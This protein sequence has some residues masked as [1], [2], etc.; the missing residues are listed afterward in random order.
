MKPTT[1]DFAVVEAVCERLASGEPLE[2]I[3]RDIGLPVRTFNE[4]CQHHEEAGKLKADA[5]EAGYDAIAAEC[6]EIADDARNDWMAK[7]GG[8]EEGLQINTEHIQRSKLRIET[9][10]KLLAKWDPKR[11]GDRQVIDHNVQGLE[12][13]I[14]AAGKPE[15]AKPE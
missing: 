5:R 8:G 13:L 2:A 12:A 1:Y 11:Y 14:A 9:R 10:L 15:A 7:Q 3:C 6:M 4:W